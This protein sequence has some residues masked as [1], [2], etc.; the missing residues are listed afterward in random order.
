M[1]QVVG[2][3]SVGMRVYLVL[4][5]GRDRADPLFLQIKQAGPSVYEEHLGRS[6]SETPASRTR[7][8]RMPTLPTPTTCLTASQNLNRSRRW[9]RYCGSESR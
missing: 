1:R 8:T 9:R 3:G 4:L 5:E 6:E 7:Y 2:V